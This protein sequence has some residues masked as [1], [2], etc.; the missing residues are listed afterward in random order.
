VNITA[1]QSV[2]DL[3][4]LHMGSEAEPHTMQ[5][6][7]GRLRGLMSCGHIKPGYHV[8]RWYWADGWV[9]ADDEWSAD[10]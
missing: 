9:R 8:E 7:V 2:P 5:T 4:I 3:Y 6:L 1:N 10:D